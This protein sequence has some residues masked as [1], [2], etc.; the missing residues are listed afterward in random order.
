MK[1][2]RSLA[3]LTVVVGTLSFASLAQGATVY[4]VSINTSAITGTSAVVA[5]DFLDGGT[6]SNSIVISGFLT[7]GSLGLQTP[8]GDVSG[9][10]PSTVTLADS[11]FFNELLAE[12]T[13]GNT[14]SFQFAATENAPD[15]ASVPDAFTVFMLDP[16]TLLP[17]F[18][19]NAPTGDALL[20]FDID[21]SAPS[22][23]LASG[24][25][26]SVTVAQVQQQVPEP[27]SLLLAS[28]VL[29]GLPCQRRYDWAKSL[30]VRGLHSRPEQ[31][32]SQLA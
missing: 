7:D 25:E 2:S 24:G 18:P 20:Q 17:L 14:L 13:L 31:Q 32:L 1:K 28:L 15:P 26:V 10:L 6:P 12:M 11:Q 23:Y 30:K 22:V 21:G 19:T 16:N 27:G 4:S 9:T 8:T 3:A 29:A 5:L